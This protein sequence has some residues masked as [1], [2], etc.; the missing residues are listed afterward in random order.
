MGDEN[1]DTNDYCLIPSHIANKGCFYGFSW[2]IADQEALAGLVAEILVSHHDHV[3]KV[4]HGAAGEPPPNKESVIRS[5]LKNALAPI[6]TEQARYHRDGLL[7][8]HISWVAAA[9]KCDEGDLLSIPHSRMSDKGQDILIVHYKHDGCFI[10]IGEDKATKNVRSTVRD[11]VFPE[12]KDY[13]SGSRDNELESATL[14]I[15]QR[16]FDSDQSQEIVNGIL[17]QHSRRYRI[18]VTV[19]TDEL[20]SN[21]SSGF[22]AGYQNLVPGEDL[23][24]RAEIVFIPN[25]QSRTDL[26]DEV[27]TAR[28]VDSEDIHT[29]R[30]WFDSFAE[31][32]TS[33]LQEMLGDLNV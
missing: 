12:L 29:L 6:R 5:V 26:L 18:N 16:N 10:S 22:F 7:F 1:I 30:L 33:R 28:Q 8:Q 20:A 27:G 25:L 2:D 9:Y 14:A 24:R 32:I 19:C 21:D 11:E 4:L 15:L 23:R 31:D 3:L 13:E 17:W